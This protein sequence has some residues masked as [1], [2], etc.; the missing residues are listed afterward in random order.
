VV[1][2]LRIAQRKRD[3]HGP[4][5]RLNLLPLCPHVSFTRDVVIVGM[6]TAIALTASSIRLVKYESMIRMLQKKRTADFFC[7]T[8]TGVRGSA[9]DQLLGMGD[10]G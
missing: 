5:T 6:S 8:K 2:D 10:P 9:T 4:E 3:H 1:G 7:R